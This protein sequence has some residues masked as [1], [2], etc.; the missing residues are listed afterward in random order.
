MADEWRK[1]LKFIS[2]KHV[3]PSEEFQ[4]KYALNNITRSLALPDTVAEPLDGTLTLSSRSKTSSRKTDLKN[5]S[6]GYSFYLSEVQNLCIPSYLESGKLYNDYDI[7]HGRVEVQVWL[8]FYDTENQCFVG[9]TW[10]SAALGS[11][12]LSSFKK[13]SALEA[14]SN[15][16]GSDRARTKSEPDA[17]LSKIRGKLAAVTAFN[18]AA[19]QRTKAAKSTESE[20]NRIAKDSNIVETPE[21]NLNDD[22]TTQASIN[23]VGDK[24]LNISFD[25]FE[26]LFHCSTVSPYVILVTEFV[27]VVPARD[28][29][30]YIG[31]GWSF[32]NIWD[33]NKQG[34]DISAYFKQEDEVARSK[35]EVIGPKSQA[36][37]SGS[38]RILT[39]MNSHTLSSSMSPL[40]SLQNSKMTFEVAIEPLLKVFCNFTPQYF[41]VGPAD[42]VPG[43]E[44]FPDIKSLPTRQ[45]VFSGIN[46]SLATEVQSVE[47]EMMK[48]LKTVYEHVLPTDKPDPIKVLERRLHIRFH[49][50]LK[51]ISSPNIVTLQSNDL[52]PFS[53]EFSGSISLD[54][55]SQGRQDIGVVFLL[56]YVV[57]LKQKQQQENGW[58]ARRL[59][60]KAPEA[61]PDLE[62]HVLLSWGSWFP[63][64]H[65]LDA[66]SSCSISLDCSKDVSVLNPN[67]ILGLSL[68]E[69]LK[70]NFSWKN[71]GRESKIIMQ[72]TAIDGASKNVPLISSV[73]TG[74]SALTKSKS[75]LD[76]KDVTRVQP[77]P[78]VIEQNPKLSKAKSELYQKN[79]VHLQTF[80]GMTLT[81][82]ERAKLMTSGFEDVLDSNGN[83][84]QNELLQENYQMLTANFDIMSRFNDNFESKEHWLL[85]CGLTFMGVSFT[86]EFGRSKKL[87]KNSYFKMQFHSFPFITTDILSCDNENTK[88]EDLEQERRNTTWLLKEKQT[89]RCGLSYSF[90]APLVR[91]SGFVDFL[92]TGFVHIELWDGDSLF[93]VAKTVV[94]LTKVFQSSS[95]K[96]EFAIC[97]DAPLFGFEWSSLMVEEASDSGENVGLLHLRLSLT[98]KRSDSNI[99][100]T[101][102]ESNE[103]IMRMDQLNSLNDGVFFKDASHV[104]TSSILMQ[105]SLTRATEKSLHEKGGQKIS[106]GIPLFDV[107]TL[108][109]SF[110]SDCLAA[111][112]QENDI[113]KS[114]IHKIKDAF[115]P[116]E[117]RGGMVGSY[118]DNLVR[119]REELQGAILCRDNTR[120]DFLSQ[121]IRQRITVIHTIVAEFGRT[122]FFE[123]ELTNPYST[124]ILVNIQWSDLDL[125]IVRDEKEAYFIR[126]S[127]NITS[128]TSNKKNG[129]T[130]NPQEVWLRSHANFKVPFVYQAQNILRC[131]KGEKKFISV[132][133]VDTRNNIVLSALDLDINFTEC[134]NITKH[135][136]WYSSVSETIIKKMKVPTKYMKS[137]STRVSFEMMDGDNDTKVFLKFRPS[138]D[139]LNNRKHEDT[140]YLIFYSDE[141]KF[142]L[143]DVWCIHVHLMHRVDVVASYGAIVKSSLLIRGNTFARSSHTSMPST[144]K[145]FAMIPSNLIKLNISDKPISLVENSEL[146]EIKFSVVASAVP[147]PSNQELT[148]LINI[149]QGDTLVAG[150]M[151][152]I[153]LKAPEITKSF[154]INVPHALADRSTQVPKKVS[155]QNSYNANK[156]FT[157]SCSD[158][159]VKCTN[160]L[161]LKPKE[162]GYIRFQFTEDCDEELYVV[163]SDENSNIEECIYIRLTR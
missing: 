121:T 88:L 57:Q 47:S 63:P 23:V 80:D 152:K 156:S 24:L 64:Q 75:V 97:F 82:S 30:L 154:K 45:I 72:W 19:K 149:T 157:I 25:D 12:T 53:L 115:Y 34:F 133:F 137:S 92:S 39:R 108:Y 159:R 120:K 141:Y 95:T 15:L 42:T 111:E 114:K 70:N 153:T 145:A 49:N 106:R 150:F 54:K 86:E 162:K 113:I 44:T 79:V 50:G 118:D 110:V 136:T 32:I 98:L 147:R 76:V 89:G 52:D 143:Q 77:E 116:N 127:L 16:N 91:S 151:V 41:F 148:S 130:D 144:V 160:E 131:T 68:D 67:R 35:L 155:F 117:Q 56:E 66:G 59:S 3:V 132:K 31:C 119:R 135:L 142:K 74:T 13:K 163:I 103:L 55:F 2:S 37:C 134:L 123:Y 14:K 71:S 105:D 85:D 40:I 90:S 69:L 128:S 78:C 94:S 21:N 11:F 109:R 48:Y 129:F 60:Q 125:R 1:R 5:S 83:I 112:E 96:A 38:P 43:M 18:S 20:S 146:N 51:Y 61:V 161:I 17:N 62:K 7:P 10:K 93:P 104:S 33:S 65:Q 81:L 126:E 158:K 107:D 73:M 102:L 99:F 58:L 4:A 9:S 22:K 36:L 140:F 122:Y 138:V 100:A 29:P 28:S 6:L 26:V 46:I 101:P 8:S 84:L 27:L 139:R 87:S 124:D